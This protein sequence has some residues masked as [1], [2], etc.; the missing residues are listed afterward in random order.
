MKA[1]EVMRIGRS[2]VR[3]ANTAA[4]N[5]VFLCS[6]ACLANST[7]RM[8]FLGGE[9]NKHDKADL[10]EYIAIQPSIGDANHRGKHAHRNNQDDSERQQPAFVKRGEK[11]KNEDHGEPEGDKSRVAGKFFLQDFAGL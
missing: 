7:I 3:A 2:L 5:R 9:T 6:S 10:N 8:A 4:S 11:Q 1:K